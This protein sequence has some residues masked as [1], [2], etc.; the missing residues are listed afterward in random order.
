MKLLYNVLGALSITAVLLTGCDQ[1]VV[2]TG[3]APEELR[4][5]AA[6][7]GPVLVPG[8]VQAEDYN[9]G[10]EGVAYHDLSQGNAGGQYR[11]DDVDIEACRDA[12]GGFN[13]GYLEAGE[14][15]NYEVG[16]PTGQD[17]MYTAICR[18]ASA[19]SGIKALSLSFASR[20]ATVEKTVSFDYADGWQSWHDVAVSLAL[21]PADMAMKITAISGGFN[22]NRIT[23]VKGQPPVA[24]AGPDQSVAVNTPVTLDGRASYDPDNSHGGYQVLT[25]SWAQLSGPAV[26]L[27]DASTATPSFTPTA[28]GSYTFRMTAKNATASRTDDVVITCGG[29][30]IKVPGTI[31]A[32][33]YVSFV[34]LTPGNNGG[35]YRTDDVDLQP[36]TDVGGGYNVGWTDAGEA[37]S[38]RI[39]VEMAADYTVTLR[40]ASGVA[41]TKTMALMLDGAAIGG[42]ISFDDAA[43]WQTWTDVQRENIPLP[44]GAH[45]L[46]IGFK[47]GGI[48]LNSLRI[49]AGGDV[50]GLKALSNDRYVSVLD[51][52]TVVPSAAE[53]STW[54]KF[55]R[56]V[57]PD[58]RIA[59][60]SLKNGRY[61]CADQSLANTQLICNRTGASGWESFAVVDNGDG[62]V[63]LQSSG[64][65]YVCAENGGTE[66]LVA[67]R[68]AIG[69]WEKFL[70]VR[71]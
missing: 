25:F 24:N 8:T 50:V 3:A 2:P 39:N 34:D 40:V 35:V 41:G 45:V 27:T 11:G 71:F 51:N 14:W 31:Q 52:N 28:S 32:E 53:A 1:R 64:G 66:P 63:S 33:D 30:A 68:T 54:E 57:L 48:N 23:F 21:P 47:T 7:A 69:G 22:L 12:G 5:A 17:G 37:L 46:T 20:Y 58:G 15:L 36:T 4:Q 42:P 62:S 56:E 44:Q 18:V 19:G 61:L 9:L 49:A 10:G 29:D 38:Y 55:A 67:N 60:K 43:G 16:V 59:F 26:S 6:T 65:T 13:V 70:L